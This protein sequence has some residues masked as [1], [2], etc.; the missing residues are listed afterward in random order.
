MTTQTITTTI[1]AATRFIPGTRSRGFPAWR[2]SA[3]LALGWLAYGL[4]YAAVLAG[5]VGPPVALALVLLGI[6]PG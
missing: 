5:V 1:T 3:A 6:W 4:F 2:G